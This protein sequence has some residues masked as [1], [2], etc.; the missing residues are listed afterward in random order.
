MSSSWILLE[1]KANQIVR[2]LEIAIRLYHMLIQRAGKKSQNKFF[3]SIFLFEIY[4]A[5]IQVNLI[6]FYYYYFKK[7]KSTVLHQGSHSH[8]STQ[9]TSALTPNINN[10]ELLLKICL[11]FAGKIWSYGEMTALC[12]S[13]SQWHW[14]DRCCFFLST[15]T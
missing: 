11:F 9:G 2:A 13:Y 12:S 5:T 7:E 8:C 15:H 4:S 14:D 10:M 6:Y 1:I 3:L